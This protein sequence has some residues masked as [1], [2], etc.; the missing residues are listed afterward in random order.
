MPAVLH[1]LC[2]AAARIAIAAAPC[3][4]PMLRCRAL[5]E[6]PGQGLPDG[7]PPSAE[8]AP[9]PAGGGGDAAGEPN[10]R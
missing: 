10:D 7:Q 4:S 6:D 9:I 3:I 2:P 1:R 5:A 8:R